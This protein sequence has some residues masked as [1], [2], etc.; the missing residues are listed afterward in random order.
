MEKTKIKKQKDLTIACFSRPSQLDDLA[1]N[2]A[3]M[4]E[5]MVEGSREGWDLLVFGEAFLQGF[6]AFSFRYRE[7]VHKALFVRSP[8][9]T[10]IR[11]WARDYKIGVAFGFLENEAGGLYS[12]YLVLDKKGSLA[13]HYRRV[14]RGWKTKEACADYREGKHFISLDFEGWRLTPLICGDFW[15]DDLLAQIIDRDPETDLF[16]WPVHCDYDQALWEE[17]ECQAYRERTRI[18]EKPI[19]LVNNYIDQADRA[20]GGVYLWHQ[21]KEVDSLPYGSP[22]LKELTFRAG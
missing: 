6:E 12:S 7:D 19:L 11:H 22:G 2:L 1:G 20:K 17:S 21:G 3:L 18:L 15:E 9:I 14:S 13:G 4:E 16:L 8:E 5:A 10:L